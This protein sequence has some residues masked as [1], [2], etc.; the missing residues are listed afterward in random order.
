M[1]KRKTFGQVA[2]EGYSAS[3]WGQ[4][5]PPEHI[6]AWESLPSDVR[7]AWQAV[8]QALSRPSNADEPSDDD[9]DNR[10]PKSEP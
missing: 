10:E 8:E 3:L 9:D 1:P 2:Y 7:N 5:H 4:T 6:P